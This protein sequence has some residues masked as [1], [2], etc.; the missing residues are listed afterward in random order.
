MAHLSVVLGILGMVSA[1]AAAGDDGKGPAPKGGAAALEGTLVGVSL[2]GF[3]S[4]RT[5]VEVRSVT[6]TKATT[7][8]G[9]ARVGCGVHVAFEPGSETRAARVEYKEPPKDEE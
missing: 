6:I 7:S 2:D 8:V 9:T 4:V 5:G 1:S 3:I